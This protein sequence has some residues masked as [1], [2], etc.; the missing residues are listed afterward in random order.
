MRESGIYSNLAWGISRSLVVHEFT[1]EQAVTVI[2][3][4]PEASIVRILCPVVIRSY[5]TR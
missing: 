4:T 5:Y 1:G 3:T 2:S